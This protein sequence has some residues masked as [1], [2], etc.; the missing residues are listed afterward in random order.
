VEMEFANIFNRLIW[1]VKMTDSQSTIKEQACLA[2]EQP[3]SSYP[4][5][6]SM[7]ER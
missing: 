2:Q 1:A 6:I 3:W 5:A 4:C 7:S